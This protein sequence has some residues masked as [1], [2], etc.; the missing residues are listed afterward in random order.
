MGGE[1]RLL[2]QM[3]N[4]VCILPLAHNFILKGHILQYLNGTFP[5]G[6]FFACVDHGIQLCNMI[7]LDDS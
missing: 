2:C 5:V 7:L 6:D 1:G 3:V 4:F